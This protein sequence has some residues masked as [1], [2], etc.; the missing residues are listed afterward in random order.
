M[1]VIGNTYSN[2]VLTIGQ[3]GRIFDEIAY[4]NYYL[5]GNYNTLSGTIAMNDI[6]KNFEKR[7]AEL[8]ILCDENV[9]YA[10][11]QTSRSFAPVE[12]SVIVEGCQWLQIR[13]VNLYDG[14]SGSQNYNFILSDWKLQ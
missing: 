9:V 13:V 14:S 4:A 6:S 12:F 11:G 3:P 10:T 5:G 1:D 8:S 7:T 2:H